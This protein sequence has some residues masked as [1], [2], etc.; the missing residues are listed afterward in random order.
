HS[1]GNLINL[2]QTNALAVVPVGEK[3]V[4]KGDRVRIMLVGTPLQT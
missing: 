1:S 3:V 4:E 2:A